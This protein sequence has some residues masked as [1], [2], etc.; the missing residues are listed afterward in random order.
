M[1][2]IKADFNRF[3]ILSHVSTEPL[4]NDQSHFRKLTDFRPKTFTAVKLRLLLLHHVVLRVV[5]NVSRE[6]LTSIC[7][8]EVDIDRPV[9]IPIHKPVPLTYTLQVEA[10]RSSAP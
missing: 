6:P 7:S 4:L 9:P 10:A 8:V 1:F 5:S 2:H 3:H